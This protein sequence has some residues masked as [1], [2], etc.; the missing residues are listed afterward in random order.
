MYK[1]KLYV[2]L[3]ADP[4]GNIYVPDNVGN[5]TLTILN[6]FTTTS[7]NTAQILTVTGNAINGPN[8]L[9]FGGNNQLL[10]TNTQDGNLFFIQCEFPR[11]T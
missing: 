7:V 6:G 5:R 1:F 2:G 4:S 11:L 3:T 9:T 10:G 8:S